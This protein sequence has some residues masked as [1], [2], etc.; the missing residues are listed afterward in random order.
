MIAAEFPMDTTGPEQ[1]DG[2]DLIGRDEVRRL[3]GDPSVSTLYSD[4][5]VR[6]LALPLTEPG[7]RV[8][9]VRW[10]RRE[11]LELRRRRISKARENAEAVRRDVV[12]RNKRRREKR[13]QQQ[14]QRATT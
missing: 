4:P 9:R 8:K 7:K 2:D 1:G 14:Q 6:A 3:L 5:E 13:R 12:E 10:L 11:I